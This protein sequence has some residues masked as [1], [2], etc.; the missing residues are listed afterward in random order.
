[1]SGFE[2]PL[3]GEWKR[4]KY[5][6]RKGKRKEIKKSVETEDISKINFWLRLKPVTG[7]TLDVAATEPRQPM[8]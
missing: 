2:G 4:G 6:E 1:M 3:H 7:E 5:E 8:D